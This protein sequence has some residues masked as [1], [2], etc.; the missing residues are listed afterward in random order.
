MPRSWQAAVCP[1]ETTWRA[2]KYL[3]R[4]WIACQLCGNMATPGSRA[5][6]P[7]NLLHGLAF[8]KFIDQF[9]QVAH[10][11]HE[12]ILNFRQ[13]HPADAAR[14]E[15][16]LWIERGGFRKEVFEIRAP[17]EVG[18]QRL[19]RISGQP[20][21]D[22]IHLGRCSAL[23][24]RLCDVVGV[25]SWCRCDVFSRSVPDS[26]FFSLRLD[27]HRITVG[28]SAGRIQFGAISRLTGHVRLCSIG[29]IIE[30]E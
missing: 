20:A 2:C 27:A 11:F 7:Q 17:L 13:F 3:T 30:H 12:G 24:L 29:N 22:F 18:F 4:L 6:R 19:L 26:S 15:R 25:C 14:D 10:L 9:I 23:F 21:N 28:E 16:A 8:G 5:S 1:R